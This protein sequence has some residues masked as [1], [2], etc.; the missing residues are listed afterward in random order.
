MVQDEDN[1]MQQQLTKMLN[2]TQA[3]QQQN[4]APTPTP[5]PYPLYPYYQPVAIAMSQQLPVMAP[6]HYNMYPHVYVAA[7]TA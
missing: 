2:L 6:Y 4:V 5:S 7:S 3:M 1:S